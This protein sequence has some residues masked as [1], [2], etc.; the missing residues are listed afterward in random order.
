[1]APQAS[2]I[3]RV[4]TIDFAKATPVDRFAPIKVGLSY[5]PEGRL[6]LGLRGRPSLRP[7]AAEAEAR[8]AA[9]NA[10]AEARMAA[11]PRGRRHDAMAAYLAGVRDQERRNGPEAHMVGP[12]LVWPVEEAPRRQLFVEARPATAGPALSTPGTGSGPSPRPH[13]GGAEATSWNVWGQQSCAASSPRFA[14]RAEMDFRRATTP[15]LDELRSRSYAERARARTAACAAREAREAAALRE[16]PHGLPPAELRKARA[17][18]LE[19]CGRGYGTPL[20]LPER[21]YQALRGSMK[22]Y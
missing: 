17:A 20:S 12:C 11:T 1:M 14:A 6:V 8:V 5:S 18:G 9:A 19:V 13:S 16:W 2:A 22:W 10:A 4:V 3:G 7:I 15:D 21:Q